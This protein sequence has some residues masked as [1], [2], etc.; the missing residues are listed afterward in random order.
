MGGSVLATSPRHLHVFVESLDTTSSRPSVAFCTKSDLEPSWNAE[1]SRPSC[2]FTPRQLSTT[3]MPAGCLRAR[4]VRNPTLAL[5]YVTCGCLIYSSTQPLKWRSD[6]KTPPTPSSPVDADKTPS[7]ALL[8]PTEQSNHHVTMYP[9][10]E[11]VLVVLDG[12]LRPTILSFP[13]RTLQPVLQHR[14][15]YPR[16]KLRRKDSSYSNPDMSADG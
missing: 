16:P 1:S 5:L 3:H 7:E 2:Y 9:T 12:P 10:R 14:Q 15:T 11:A 13:N 4:L 8:R 6:I